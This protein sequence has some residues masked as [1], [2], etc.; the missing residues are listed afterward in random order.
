MIYF[1][2]KELDAIKARNALWRGNAVLELMFTWFSFSNGT[3]PLW[4]FKIANRIIILSYFEENSVTLFCP[5]SLIAYM[6]L[7]QAE[8]YSFNN[9]Y[10]IIC[11]F[12][13]RKSIYRMIINSRDHFKQV[14]TSSIP[15]SL[16]MSIKVILL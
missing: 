13:Q 14:I 11:Y 9:L 10:N 7:C 6:H 5:M 12:D 3:K 15:S 8:N 1:L 16:T 2:K 4:V